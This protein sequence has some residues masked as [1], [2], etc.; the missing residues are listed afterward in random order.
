MESSIRVSLIAIATSCG[1]DVEASIRVVDGLPSSTD[2]SADDL[3]RMVEQA[4]NAAA[5]PSYA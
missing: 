5:Y 3:A 1:L 2:A 4:A